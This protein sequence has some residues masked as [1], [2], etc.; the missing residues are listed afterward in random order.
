MTRKRRA[1]TGPFRAKVALAAIRGEGTLAELAP[2]DLNH[3]FFTNSG[4]ESIDTALKIVM[5]YNRARGEAQRIR[6]AT[7]IGSRLMGVLYTLDEPSIIGDALEQAGTVLLSMVAFL[8]V[9]AAFALPI[10][11]V[12]AIGYAVWRGVTGGRK[13]AEPAE[14]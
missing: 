4:S 7:Q 8:I 3:V 13:E 12:A 9:A 6:L 5:A 11:I 1:F 2:G 14:A 10:G